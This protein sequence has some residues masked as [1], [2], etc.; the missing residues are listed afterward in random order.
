MEQGAWNVVERSD[1]HLVATYKNVFVTMWWAPARV[2]QLR[3]L[4][5]HQDEMGRRWPGGWGTLAVL[6]ADAGKISAEVRAEG[7][8]ITKHQKQGMRAIAQVIEGT[9]FGAAA[10]RSVASALTLFKRS[11][12]PTKI[13]D[14][15]GPGVAWLM[16]ELGTPADAPALLKALRAART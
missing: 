15:L 1:G 12:P 10:V 6:G 9:G 5:A 14:A 4:P 16:H 2:E 11:G 7:E 8:R 3:G 13:F